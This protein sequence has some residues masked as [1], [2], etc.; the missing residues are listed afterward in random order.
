MRLDITK[1][2]LQ[3]ANMSEQQFKLELGVFLYRQGMLTQ[4]KA[5]EFS[6][7]HQIVFQKELAKRNIPVSYDQEEFEKDFAKIKAK[8][9]K[10]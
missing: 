6:G 2:M 3:Q 1:E 5:A 7:V 10:I 9:G 8:Y 4:G